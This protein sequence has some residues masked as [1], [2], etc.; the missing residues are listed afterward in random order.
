LALYAAAERGHAEVVRLLLSAPSLGVNKGDSIRCTPLYAAAQNGHTQVVRLLLTAPS[1]DVNDAGR[2]GSAPLL[3]AID[4]KHFDVVKLLLSTPALDV[5]KPDLFDATPLLR[6]VQ[7]GHIDAVQLL[8]S[9]DGIDASR[10]SRFG[11]SPLHL[12]ARTKQHAVATLLAMHHSVYAWYCEQA[13]LSTLLP[14]LKQQADMM[15]RLAADRVR[16][17]SLLLLCHQVLERKQHLDTESRLALGAV[18]QPA[19]AYINRQRSDLVQHLMLSDDNLQ[20]FDSID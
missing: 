5:N 3:I 1:L 12:A 14:L 7:A 13:S 19:V 20:L 8:L 17:A 9:V 16:H 4:S 11:V 18:P 15:R 2:C 6:V 10:Q